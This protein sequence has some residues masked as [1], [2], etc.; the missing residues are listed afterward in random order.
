MQLRRE[1]VKLLLYADNKILY[2]ENTKGSAQKVLE[3]KITNSV[4]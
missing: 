2:M 1:E 3:L 4:R